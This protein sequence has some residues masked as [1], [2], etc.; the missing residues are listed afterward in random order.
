MGRLL[1]LWSQAAGKR[2]PSGVVGATRRRPTNLQ[3]EAACFP[4]HNPQVSRDLWVFIMID[5]GIT[6]GVTKISDVMNSIPDE[7]QWLLP[8][9][10]VSVILLFA[11]LNII[12]M[13]QKMKGFFPDDEKKE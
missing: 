12:A 13:N 11:A 2:A 7:Y 4:L 3:S 9:G 5:Q 6:S 10:F 1:E 8:F